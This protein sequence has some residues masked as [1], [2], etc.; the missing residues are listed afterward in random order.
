MQSARNSLPKIL[1]SR[2]LNKLLFFT[3]GTKDLLEHS[4]ANLEQK[5]EVCVDG[6]IIPL[7]SVEGLI[8]LN[9]PSWGAGVRP[10]GK[11]ADMP[12]YLN[13]QMFEVFAVRSSFHIAQLQVGVSEPVRVAQGRKIMLRLFDSMLPMQCDGEAWIQ[14][15]AVIEVTHRD[16][17]DMLRFVQR[18]SVTARPVFS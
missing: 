4:C 13:D 17:V 3:F 9:I 18:P 1:S 15:P 8:I 6:N 7:P 10:W 11:P 16:Q 14:S 5:L 12:Q 2:F